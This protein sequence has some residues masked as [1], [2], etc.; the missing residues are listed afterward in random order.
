MYATDRQSRTEKSTSEI[1]KQ[2]ELFSTSECISSY[3]AHHREEDG[4]ERSQKIYAH[5][6][7]GQMRVSLVMPAGKRAERQN[8]RM[9]INVNQL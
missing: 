5:N 1:E 3:F 4:K 9:K 6:S 7:L 2:K 8:N